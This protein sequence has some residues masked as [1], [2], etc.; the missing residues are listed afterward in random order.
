MIHAPRFDKLEKGVRDDALIVTGERAVAK[1]A[2]SLG[3][4]FTH[5]T[6]GTPVEMDA[7][8]SGETLSTADALAGLPWHTATATP[9]DP[10]SAD[11]APEMGE[12]V[13]RLGVPAG[14]TFW[15]IYRPDLD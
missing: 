9:F 5:C 8:L 15:L 7:I 4:E 10:K 13:R 11:E 14:R 3:G 6:L 2:P 1:R 12:G